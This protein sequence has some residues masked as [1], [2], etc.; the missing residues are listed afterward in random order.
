MPAVSMG[1]R[2]EPLLHPKPGAVTR[3][4]HHPDKGVLDYAL[5]TLAVDE[6]LAVACEAGSIAAGLRAYARLAPRVVSTNTSAGTVLLLVPLAAA[7]PRSESP[8]SAA[9]E[10]ARLAK[11][12]GS[13]AA[14][15][16][17]AILE[18]YRPSHLRR[19]RGPLPPVGGGGRPPPLH[20]VLEEASWD[21]VHSE[22]LHG[23]PESLR[24][25]RALAGSRSAWE[26]EE[27]ALEALLDLLARRGD[28]LIL[29][30]WGASA[31]ERALLEARAAK[32]LAARLG[33]AAALEWL[34]S[35]WR[36][37]RWNPGAALDVLAAG[38]SLHFLSQTLRLLA[39]L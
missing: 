2:L 29:A 34:D 11:A 13:D 21:L 39:G 6:A 19:Y 28:T 25:A 14:E 15:A 38:I 17:Y 30:K 33:P 36:P 32:K 35:L 16:Y 18:A 9:A 31:Y 10:A 37:R 7:A 22:I 3:L 26:I 20:K 5:A 23:Y 27:R 12:A 1:A 4:N 24:V 8:V